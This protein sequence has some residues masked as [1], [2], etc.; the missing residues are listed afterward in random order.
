LAGQTVGS[1]IV[2]DVSKYF[3]K[4]A[5]DPVKKQLPC[6]GVIRDELNLYLKPHGLFFWPQY[7]YLIAV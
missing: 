3:T 4:I 6:N 1:G 5:F 7:F 2:V